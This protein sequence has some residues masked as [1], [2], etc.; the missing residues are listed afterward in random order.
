M[1]VTR[2]DSVVGSV[3][4]VV[5]AQDHGLDDT[6]AEVS[7]APLPTE[8]SKELKLAKEAE[9]VLIAKHQSMKAAY[10]SKAKPFAKSERLLDAEE[11][12]TKAENELHNTQTELDTMNQTVIEDRVELNESSKIFGKENRTMAALVAKMKALQKSLAVALKNSR[13]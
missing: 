12:T 4:I 1:K 2:A 5:S 10:D 3:R 7:D 11:N 8:E 6:E 9:K 13:N